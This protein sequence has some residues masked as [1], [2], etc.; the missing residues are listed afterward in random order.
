MHLLAC[1][2]ARCALTQ[3][4]LT[5]AKQDAATGDQWHAMHDSYFSLNIVAGPGYALNSGLS[6]HYG[7]TKTPDTA[8]LSR[9]LSQ[10]KKGQK[11]EKM[12]RILW[13]ERRCNTDTMSDTPRRP[14]GARNSLPCGPC[15][16]GM[17]GGGGGNGGNGGSYNQ[18][19]LHD[20]R[21]KYAEVA[22]S[23]HFSANTFKKMAIFGARRSA[24][25]G[26]RRP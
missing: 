17:K 16:T 14:H 10:G 25:Q 5:R 15:P 7:E 22:T 23:K 4:T 8:S 21:E 2:R 19:R 12:K 9:L 6:S 26:L 1:A 24:T 3:S 11:E 18:M 13:G 20:M